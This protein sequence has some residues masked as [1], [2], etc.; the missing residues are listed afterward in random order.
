MMIVSPC[1]KYGNSHMAELNRQTLSYAWNMINGGI[2]SAFVF[3]T[4]KSRYYSCLITNQSIEWTARHLPNR[5]P[6]LTDGQSFGPTIIDRW[7]FVEPQAI[8]KSIALSP[9]EQS[10]L[11]KSL[12]CVQLNRD[13]SKVVKLTQMTAISVQFQQMI[14]LLI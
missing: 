13:R 8:E 12:V 2:S 10:M 9:F 7:A 3:A 6:L 5:F 4:S 1:V 14:S 11:L